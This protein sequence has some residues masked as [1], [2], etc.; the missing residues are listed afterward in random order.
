MALDAAAADDD[1]CNGTLL[2]PET[3]RTFPIFR[4]WIV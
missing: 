4:F 2:H 3:A 1:E